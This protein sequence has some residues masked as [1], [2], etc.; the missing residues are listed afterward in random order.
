M[1]V[2]RRVK[3]C[4]VTTLLIAALPFFTASI[5][6]PFVISARDAQAQQTGQDGT[7]E[8]VDTGGDTGEPIDDSGNSGDS[9]SENAVQARDFGPDGVCEFSS[10]ISVRACVREFIAAILTGLLTIAGNVLSLA[11]QFFDVVIQ[12]QNTSFQKQRIVVEGWQITRDVVNILYIFVLLIIAISIILGIQ[13]YG[14][15][16]LLARL[17]ISALLVNFS[18]SIAGVVIDASNALGNTFYQNMGTVE[19]RGGKT[20]RDLSGSFIQGFQPQK[21]FDDQNSNFKSKGVESTTWSMIIALIAGLILLGIAIFVL[22]A[23]ALILIARI[24]ALWILLIL[25]PIAFLFYVLPGTMGLAN[26]WLRKLFEQSFFYPAYMFFLYLTFVMIK[27]GTV[28]RMIQ[29]HESIT[30]TLLN[31]RGEAF[32]SITGNISIIIQFVTLGFLMMAS[33]FVAKMLGGQTAT[34]A[35]KGGKRVSGVAQ[36][37]AGRMGRAA[38][39]RT[40]GEASRQFLDTDAAKRL[41]NRPIIGQILRVPGALKRR[42]EEHAE[43]RTA[44]VKSRSE[45]EAYADLRAHPLD[46]VRQAKTFANMTTNQAKYTM[47]HMNVEE[48]KKFIERV[49]AVDPSKQLRHKAAVAIMGTEGDPEKKSASAMAVQGITRPER[50]FVDAENRELTPEGKEYEQK[51]ETFVKSLS[52]AELGQ[53]KAETI[54]S[55]KDFRQALEVSG[56]DV[57]ALSELRTASSDVREAFTNLEREL[58]SVTGRAVIRNNGMT[59][60]GEGLTRASFDNYDAAPTEVRKKLQGLMDDILADIDEKAV[61]KFKPEALSNEYVRNGVFKTFGGRDMQRLASTKENASA[62]REAIDVQAG[63]TPTDSE[64]QALRKRAEYIEQ[65]KSSNKRL[66]E[67]FETTAGRGVIVEGRRTT[68]RDLPTPQQQPPQ[69]APPSQPP[70]PPQPPPNNP[71]PTP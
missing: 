35:L 42:Q 45:A 2:S 37:Y 48:R 29:D 46:T 44:G 33:I 71:P 47:Q 28:A 65:L 62:V 14:S 56:R 63:I 34:I 11:G 9:I 70:P 32:A 68:K 5:L 52:N 49:D 64:L 50:M 17:V 67:F 53:T 8:E 41:A 1:I 27:S 59:I 23:G 39:S 51:L 60:N 10:D 13:S 15:K 57:K 66:A 25:S 31:A 20:T 19:T 58:N 12:I 24:V 43:K 6:A 4:I 61:P 36:G 69:E 3:N 55:D 22:V 40:V 7:T 16:A 21:I 38:E 18:L 26:T 54:D 30:D